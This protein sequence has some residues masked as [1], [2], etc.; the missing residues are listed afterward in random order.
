MKN[1]NKK[2]RWIIGILAALLG[3]VLLL[4]GSFVYVTKY[5]ITDIDKSASPDGEYEVTY[6]NIG[7]PDFPYGYAHARLVLRRGTETIAECRFDVANDGGRPTAV[8][9]VAN[10]TDHCAEVTISGDEQPDRLYMLYYNGMTDW[11][12]AETEQHK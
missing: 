8:Q 7:E 11:K 12:E 6:Q 10:W 5:R 3:I 9:W 4:L 1:Q 2:K